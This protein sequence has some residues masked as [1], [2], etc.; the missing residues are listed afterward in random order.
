MLPQVSPDT[1]LLSRAE[2]A[3][4][5]APADYIDAVAAAFRALAEGA[6]DSLP[7][8]HVPGLD[9][10]FHIKAATRRGAEPWVV[11]KINGN[12]PDNPARSGLPTI[13][14]CLL[15]A[16]GGDGRLLA[17]MDSS[18]IT[19][20]RTA[21]ASA[22]A[23]RL[24]ARRSADTLGLIGCGTQARYHLGTLL[25]LREFR[26]RAVHCF[27]VDA[28]SAEA[29]A[30]L[31]RGAGLVARTVDSP[32]AACRGAQVVVT[33]TP[34]RQPL[35][36]AADVEPGTFV[37]AV[38]ADNPAKCEIAADL[39]AS[40]RVVPDI[41]AQAA[42]MGDL[43]SALAGGAMTIEQVHGELAQVVCGRVPGRRHDGEI[44]VFDSTGTAIEDLAAADLVYRRAVKR[45]EP[46]RVAFGRAPA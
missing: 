15:L 3:A 26:W 37:A 39:M 12:F 6:W 33:S 35:L 22:V 8:G 10:A 31:A 40:A 2:I 41:L 4:L 29:L 20:Q 30:A 16:H 23:A 36:H 11:I 34:S 24:L 5:T 44:F 45:S 7:V 14:G 18:E 43:R 21:A 32:A 13:Q 1:L 28:T 19:A 17:I 38:G 25:A 42:S 46:L 9:G 27:D